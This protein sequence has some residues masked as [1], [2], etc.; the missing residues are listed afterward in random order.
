M[1]L[2]MLMEEAKGMTDDALMEVIHY[3]QF[4]KTVP[5]NTVVVAV[6]QTINNQ[7]KLYRKPGIYKNKIKILEEFDNI[8]DD[9]EEYI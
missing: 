4:L 5:Q 6:S 8:P 9:F 3:M 2:E 7:E 1:P